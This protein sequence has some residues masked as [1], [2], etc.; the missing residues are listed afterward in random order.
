MSP[1]SKEQF[2]AIREESKAKILDAALGL[3]T[4]K[5]FEYTSINNIATEAGISK[6]LIYNYFK[7]KDELLDQ[8]L[9]MIIGR[10]SE[11]FLPSLEIEEPDKRLEYLIRIHFNLLIENPGFWKMFVGLSIQLDKASNAYLIIAQYWAHLFD[12]AILIFKEMG[13]SNPEKT[14]YRYGAIMDGLAMQYLVL[15]KDHLP[16]FEQTL[17]DVIKEFCTPSNT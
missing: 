16:Q 14:A 12:N 8:T 11:V 9:L 4:S 2:E 1:L 13:L 6:G 17:E 10:L 3:F 7:S 5:G 15:G